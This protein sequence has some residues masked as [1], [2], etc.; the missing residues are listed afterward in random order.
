ML[1]VELAMVAVLPGLGTGSPV[2]AYRTGGRG[3]DL[4]AR[5]LRPPNR[6]CPRPSADGVVLV[7]QVVL[8]FRWCGVQVVRR[9]GAR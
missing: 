4:G 6:S 5:V 2:A 8:S 7:Q 1:E 3:V 9:P